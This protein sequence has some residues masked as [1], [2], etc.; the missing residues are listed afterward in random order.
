V[1]PKVV[2]GA[3]LM[4]LLCGSLWLSSGASTNEAMRAVST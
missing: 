1:V 3:Y 4:L 2:I